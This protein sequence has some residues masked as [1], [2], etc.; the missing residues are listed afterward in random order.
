MHINTLD[1][2]KKLVLEIKDQVSKSALLEKPE[3]KKDEAED[4]KED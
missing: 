1:E 2:L 4:E 3:S